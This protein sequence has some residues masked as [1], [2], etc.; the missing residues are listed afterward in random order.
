MTDL[1]K[2]VLS[3][4]D[5]KE[6]VEFLQKLIRCRSDYPPGDT[7]EVAEACRR[8]F[9]E[10]GIPAELIYP[11]P[12]TFT[13][14]NDHVDVTKIPSVIGTYQGDKEGPVLLY[15]A[16]IDTVPGDNIKNWRNDPFSGIIEDG[17]YIYGRGAGD[18]KGSVAAQVMAAVILARAGIKLKGT[19]QISP[20]AD[21]E[22]SSYRGTKFL[23]DEGY[24]K[25]DIVVIGEQTDNKIAVAERGVLWMKITIIG[26]GAHA[27][28]PW[29]GNNAVARAAEFVN[30]INTEYADELEKRTNP[31]LPH[32]TASVTGFNGGIKD[33]VI[34]ELCTLT[35]DR[36]LV[37]GETVEMAVG[38]IKNL[39]KK[40]AAD[41]SFEWDVRVTYD[42]GPPV[43]TQPNDPLI[44]SMLKIKEELTGAPDQ[45][46]GY[47]QGSD[48]RL[49]T[50]LGIPIA[51]Y[52]PSDPA[53][54]HAPNERVSI[55]QLLEAT[56]VYILIAMRILGCIS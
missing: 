2:K 5:E 6:V 29:A 17:K 28:M 52:G 56:R 51:I 9:E 26:K 24:L 35:I 36:R 30:L 19:L 50:H 21:E 37:P 44:Q 25:P 42:A 7:R 46:I 40:A 49:F 32:A 39:L 45:P 13:I 33:N 55:E 15:N 1:E 4:V 14:W 22:A 8:K 16:H 41:H 48:G 34:P 18:D 3:E 31:Y 20:V 11:H 12:D 10:A 54:G 53:V 23:R 47:R 27:A 43:N 38:E